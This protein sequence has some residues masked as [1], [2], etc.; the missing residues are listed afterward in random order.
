MEITRDFLE[1]IKWVGISVFEE[2]KGSLLILI[3]K[4]KE[5]AFDLLDLLYDHPFKILSGENETKNIVLSLEFP[6]LNFKVTIV[7]PHDKALT[8][9]NIGVKRFISTG[10]ELERGNLNV[11]EADIELS[12]FNYDASLN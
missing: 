12:H 2:D 7:L 3:C 4:T 10:Y 11:I 8:K 1:T 9:L 5:Q 6:D